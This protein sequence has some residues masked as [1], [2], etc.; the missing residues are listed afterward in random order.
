MDLI[1]R[2]IS[3]I[4]FFSFC[5]SQD[6]KLNENTFSDFQISSEKYL[7]DEKGNILMYVNVWGEVNQPG[8]HLVYEGIDFATL[9]SIV[10]GPIKGANLKKVKL[11]REV[12]DADG[13]LTY[14][15]NLN[16]FLVSGDRKDF[17]QIK[18]NDTILIPTKTST[19][20]LKQIGTINTIFSLITLYLTINNQNQ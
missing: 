15:I 10:G 4:T 19:I 12:P 13:T 17:V 1:F 6:I 8:H 7:T 5:F 11:H 16:K 18:P 3:I 2:K 9:L 20:V 14:N